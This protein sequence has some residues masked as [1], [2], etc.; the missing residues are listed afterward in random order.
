VAIT[1]LLAV[2]GLGPVVLFGP[3]VGGAELG[4]S[5]FVGLAA[6]YWTASA[7]GW[8][9]IG[10]L[11]V[12]PGMTRTLRPLTSAAA[13][14]TASACCGAVQYWLNKAGFPRYSYLEVDGH[15]RQT[16]PT[17]TPQTTKETLAS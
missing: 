4:P 2:V 8:C 13:R 1:A 3:Q 17:E 5:P 12:R 7:C 15:L 16:H 9:H 11:R 10:E 14:A 6:M